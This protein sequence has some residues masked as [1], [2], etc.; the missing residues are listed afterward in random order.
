MESDVQ[1]VLVREPAVA[2]SGRITQREARRTGER[3]RTPIPAVI[4]PVVQPVA[5]ASGTASIN[6]WDHIGTLRPAQRACIVIVLPNRGRY[7]P[8]QR[9]N[10]SEIPTTDD[11]IGDAGIRPSLAFTEWQIP[12]RRRDEPVPDIVHRKT[13]LPADVVIVQRDSRTLTE[14]AVIAKVIVERLGECVTHPE[15]QASPVDPSFGS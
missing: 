1:V 11:F 14:E 2:C 9:D 13:V 6:T 8:L 12:Y 5:F 4:K 10:W 7:A 3:R 15:T